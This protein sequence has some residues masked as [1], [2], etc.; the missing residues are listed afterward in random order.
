MRW[1]GFVFL[2]FACA[3]LQAKDFSSWRK[4]SQGELIRETSGFAPGA[5][6]TVGLKINLADKWHT[7]WLNP[8]DSGTAIHLSFK[9]SR[10]VKVER[11]LFPIPEREVS[12]PLISFGYTRQVV[13]PIELAIGKELSPG[14]KASV[15]VDVEWLVCE[16]VCIPAFDA[17]HIDVP[18]Q[19]LEDVSPSADFEL[20]KKFR[21][22]VPQIVDDYP[23]FTFHGD[24]AMLKVPLARMQDKLIEFF[25]FKNS[26]VSNVKPQL[27]ADTLQFE[28]SSV[29]I[30]GPERVGVLVVR[31]RDSG[32][33]QAYQF[34][35][36][37][38]KFDAK[39]SAADESV[40]WMLL[41]AFIGGL[42]L[43]LMPCVFPILS[44]KLL[45]LMK[46]AQAHPREVRLQN[47]S[48]VAGVLISFLGIALLLS[49]LRSAGSLIGWGFQLQSPVFLVLLCWLFFALSLN[50]L[51]VYELELLD[52]NLG[53]KLTR[54]G[55]VWGSFFT[56]VLAVIVASP[57][58]APFMGV[59]LG[60]GLAQPT[61][62]L[63]V[64]FL[65]LGLGLAFPYLLFVIFPSWV[66]RMPRPGAWMKT[67]KQVMALPLLL[68]T[69]WLMW[70]LSQVRGP[71]ALAIVAAGCA[72]LG[73][74]LFLKRK[75]LGVV[76]ALVLA[77]GAVFIYQMREPSFSEKSSGNELW[78]PYSEKRLEEL[79]GKN[80]FVNMTADWCL[81]CKVNERLVF[82][83]AEVQSLLKAKNVIWLKGDWT[84]R[85]EEI[86]R[87]LNRYDRVGVPFYVLYSLQ[88]PAGTTLPEVLTKA[89]FIE[90]INKEFP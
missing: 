70:I 44:I 38:W 32:K 74:A 27:V 18:V 85:N 56:G 20:F 36:S 22:L 51:G 66:N 48:Y 26:G 29:S 60:F 30:A 73:F 31:S 37:G 3:H 39:K 4:Y 21:A 10:G 13:I 49:L 41:S 87:F 47:L 68:T 6:G 52:A 65:M 76:A 84:Q 35:D 24:E 8:G 33:L 19:R 78:Q 1:L 28:K 80:V 63:L 57:C 5:I 62:I 42:I 82:D 12:G 83:T 2:F 75:F 34:G 53:H 89:S 79:K 58:T 81:T 15:D 88:N 61:S 71:D 69:L 25:P 67:V 46:L 54:R 72:A 9:T 86:T 7:Y 43:N 16:D 77:A 17:F 59:A 14:D 11:V 50:L 64:V 23:H 90:F 45:S 55:G 40:W